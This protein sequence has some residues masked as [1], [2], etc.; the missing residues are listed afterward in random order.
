M[1]CE[2]SLVALGIIC[3]LTYKQRN[4]NILFYFSIWSIAILVDLYFFRDFFVPYAPGFDAFF[5]IFISTLFISY[6]IFKKLFT[7]T[8]IG[9]RIRFKGFKLSYEQY[10]AIAFL[11]ASV[12]IV[13][14]LKSVA[15]MPYSVVREMIASRQLSFHIGISFPIVCSVVYFNNINGIKKGEMLIRL[16][17]LGL[18]LI[19]TSKIFIILS[20]L[21]CIP[22]YVKGYKINLK[23][24]VIYASLAFLAFY[25]FHIILGRTG[26]GE[27]VFEKLWNT[28]NGYLVGSL[29]IFQKFFY[30]YEVRGWQQAGSWVGN[31]A[32]AFAVFYAERSYL[33][34][35]LR[36][37]ILGSLYAVMDSLKKDDFFKIYTVFPL[38]FIYFSDLY[39]QGIVQFVM[40]FLCSIIIKDFVKPVD[41][42]SLL[43]KRKKES[44][45]I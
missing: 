39:I 9:I 37:A 11:V 23:Q 28:F 20:L 29:A 21:Y 18:A 31:V 33:I 7:I 10:R 5:V 35:M 6:T 16:L 40:F 14:F 19:S 32:T 38:F 44:I 17:L 26:I 12:S 43:K 45:N 27:N 8:N 36:I 13:L 15:T 34:F 24:I 2:L 1:G 41:D 22:W 4:K 30:G 25:I 42:N 3:L